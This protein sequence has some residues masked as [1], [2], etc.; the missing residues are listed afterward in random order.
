[1]GNGTIHGGVTKGAEPFI[2]NIDCKKKMDDKRPGK[3]WDKCMCQQLCAKIKK[4][5]QA[6]KKGKIKLTPGAR[7]TNDYSNGKS[8]YIKSFMKR[9]GEG[10]SVRRQFIHKCAANKYEKMSPKNPTEGGKNAP[11]NADHMHE[12]ALGGDLL[13]MSNFKMLDGRVNQTISFQKYDPD[14]KHKG[15]PIKAHPSCNCPHGPA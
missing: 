11:F 6:R 1:M 2:V 13:S 5:D 8:N 10:R 12:A 9:V 15:K 4:M 7:T 14:G 3:K